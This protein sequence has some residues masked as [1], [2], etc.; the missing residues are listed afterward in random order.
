[1]NKASA[2]QL[3]IDAALQE[4]YDAC[5]RDSGDSDNESGDE[6]DQDSA[7]HWRS[8]CR[9]PLRG[10]ARL[11]LYQRGSVQQLLREKECHTLRG[12]DAETTASL[13]AKPLAFATEPHDDTDLASTVLFPSEDTPSSTFGA[14]DKASAG[15][16]CIVFDALSALRQTQS[17][18]FEKKDNTSLGRSSGPPVWALRQ[19]TLLVST[20]NALPLSAQT[21]VEALVAASNDVARAQWQLR[22]LSASSHRGDTK[23]M[24]D[25][26]SHYSMILTGEE[27]LHLTASLTLRRFC[28]VVQGMIRQVADWA[29]GLQQGEH[30]QQSSPVRWGYSWRVNVLQCLENVLLPVRRCVQI[31]EQACSLISETSGNMKTTSEQVGVVVRASELLDFL[32]V[33]TSALQRTSTMGLYRFYMVLLVY[34]SLPYTL[35]MTCAIFGFVTDIDPDVWRSSMPRIFRLSF[36]HIRVGDGQGDKN[37]LMLPTDILSLVFLCVGYERVGAR[38][39]VCNNNSC[40]IQHQELDRARRRAAF[41]AMMF[42]RSFILHSFVAFAKQK[43]LTGWRRRRSTAQGFALCSEP[44]DKTFSQHTDNVCGS[45]EGPAYAAL[46]LVLCSNDECFPTLSIYNVA[47]WWLQVVSDKA[48][49]DITLSNTSMTAD[50][51]ECVQLWLHPSVPAAR[52]V[53][54][55]LL[56]PL[57][58]VVQRLQEQRVKELL[59]ASLRCPDGIARANTFYAKRRSLGQSAAVTDGTCFANDSLTAV[60]CNTRAG[61]GLPTET[62]A[63]S[64]MEARGFSFIDYVGLFIDVA[65]CRDNERIVHKFLFRLL[66]E[67]HWWYRCSATE[68]VLDGTASQFITTSFAEA[69]RDHPLGHCVRL[70]VAPRDGDQLGGTDGS[71]PGHQLE[72]LRTFDSFELRFALPLDVDLILLPQN[73]SVT[74]SEGGQLQEVYTSCFWNRRIGCDPKNQ[75]RCGSP[76]SS[77]HQR[78]RGTWCYIFGYL[79]RCFMLKYH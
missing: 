5:A 27:A 61:D 43:T 32:I 78:R 24:E 17:H 53:T 25:G 73:L 44:N 41:G 9:S 29:L 57:A 42:S 47:R 69:M 39:V 28:T 7:S 19:D 77:G 15:E 68:C 55:G 30:F 8:T 58:Q 71:E 26:L 49:H 46:P 12:K 14:V 22:E 37:A 18:C 21:L 35:L 67:P 59:A 72:M 64:M 45:V 40:D 6:S 50:G 3:C 52:W 76:T 56:V 48:H 34:C 60:A 16:K 66:H 70:H 54:A 38:G 74:W 36:S 75:Q 33:R 65:L 79:W 13:L 23:L 11:R 63:L 4:Y 10:K 51:L 1:M 31:M 62:G 20:L 2:S